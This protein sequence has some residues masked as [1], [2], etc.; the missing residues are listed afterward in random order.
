MT[1]SCF[2]FAY[3]KAS[4]IHPECFVKRN[5]SRDSPRG[6]SIHRAIR[7]GARGERI[8][9]IQHELVQLGRGLL[10]R[11]QTSLPT[12]ERRT[13]ARDESFHGAFLFMRS[14]EHTSELQ[15]LMR[16]PYAVFCLKKKKKNNKHKK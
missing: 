4:A 3:P 14:E 1:Y 12:E 6:S 7:R 16:I 15:S 11:I 10:R 8:L 2:C 5:G 13:D 9:M